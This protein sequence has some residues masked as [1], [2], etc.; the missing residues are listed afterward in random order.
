M[1]KL[2]F[3]DFQFRFQQIKD[4]SFIFDIIRK[5]FIQL[6]PEEW[7]RQHF[8]HLLIDYY[9]YPKTLLKIES[10]HKYNQLQKRTDILVYDRQGNCFMLIE[11]KA[12]EIPVSKKT[13]EQVSAYNKS[14]QA[15]YMAV[16]NGIKHY[17]CCIDHTNNSFIFLDNIPT[18]PSENLPE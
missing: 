11:C 12:P 16:S 1:T 8:I 18:Y 17:C 4:K 15:P 6:T 13:F 3:P 9:H 7:V 10:G 14:Y 5:K 2:N